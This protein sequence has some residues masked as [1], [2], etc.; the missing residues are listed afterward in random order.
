MHLG[1]CEH[2]ILFMQI[3]LVRVYTKLKKAVEQ[4]DF[5]TQNS[6]QVSDDII[7]KTALL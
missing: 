7:I 3:R 5:F 2:A 4:L 6:W 1:D